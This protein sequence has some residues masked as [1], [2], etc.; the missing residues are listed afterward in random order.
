MTA[1]IE[2]HAR[3]HA[4]E[5]CL[6]APG[7][8][9]TPSRMSSHSRLPCAAL[10]SNGYDVQASIGY[11]FDVGPGKAKQKAK[12]APAAAAAAAPKQSKQSAAA[13]AA[14][15]GKGKQ[16]MATVSVGKAG[17]TASSAA[18]AG[19]SGSGPSALAATAAA[20][21]AGS[22]SLHQ[23]FPTA[24]GV[25]HSSSTHGAGRDHGI[26]PGH[27]ASAGPAALPAVPQVLLDRLTTEKPRVSI[28]VIGHVDAGKS[29]M[30]GHLLADLGCISERTM[31]K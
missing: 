15:A 28:V 12:A 25:V 3:M 27:G 9:F 24:P 19:G 21:D 2:A 20:L 7:P 23:P 17:A 29:T 1:T 31:A 14:P 6:A 30:M 5:L 10:R 16:T 18:K 13:A 26:T 8:R 11:L 4:S 22:S